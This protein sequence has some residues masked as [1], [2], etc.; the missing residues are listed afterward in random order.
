MAHFCLLVVTRSPDD[1]ADALKP[2]WDDDSD[3]RRQAHF[4][5]V[6]DARA[7]FGARR[8]K[9]GRFGYWKNPI[10]KWDG[11]TIG[12]RWSGLLGPDWPTQGAA[13]DAVHDQCRAKDLGAVLPDRPEPLAE[14]YA[15]LVYGRW[16]DV[17]D[18]RV[19]AE[20]WRGEVWRTLRDLDEEAWVTVVDCH[21]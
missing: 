10:G 19:G 6:E 21:C 16:R 20:G 2:F 18:A 11:W 17:E 3:D 15:L 4:I 12:G 13:P 8:P 5:F 9:T 7:V 14:V 1:V